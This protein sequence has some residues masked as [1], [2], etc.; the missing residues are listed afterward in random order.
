MP[1][2]KINISVSALS[3]HEYE[4]AFIIPTNSNEIESAFVGGVYMANGQLISAS[5]IKT[6]SSWTDKSPEIV[7]ESEITKHYKGKSIYLGLITLM[8]GHIFTDSSARFWY[9]I[10]ENRNFEKLVF[11]D[12][13][14]DILKVEDKRNE[15]LDILLDILDIPTEKI[16]IV[17]EVSSFENLI[18]PE[19]TIQG[20]T[21]AHLEHINVFKI[22]ASHCKDKHSDILNDWKKNIYIANTDI[23]R[24][25][26]Q[27]KNE[28][29]I[30]NFFESNDYSII[31]PTKLTLSKQIAIIANAD[32]IATLTGTNLYN[33]VFAKEQTTL[34]SIAN[35]K[36]KGRN[37]GSIVIFNHLTQSQFFHIQYVGTTYTS[38]SC[39]ID[40]ENLKGQIS[41]VKESKRFV[42]LSNF[43]KTDYYQALKKLNDLQDENSQYFEIGTNTGNSIK[44]AKA[45][46]VGV[47]PRFVIE[48]DVSDNKKELRFYQVPSDDFFSDYLEKAYRGKKIDLA[49]I[50]GLHHADQ[51]F[52]DIINTESICKSESIITVHDIIPIDDI[53]AKRKRGP[54]QGAW[55]GDVWKA[56]YVLMKERADLKFIFLDCPPSGLLL[57]FNPNNKWK[58]NNKGLY[59]ELTEKADRLPDETLEEYLKMIELV[60]TE[61]FINNF[62]L[63][64][65]FEGIT[66]KR[67]L[68]LENN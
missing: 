62:K 14:L 8:Y 22:I 39:K 59:A 37:Y 11:V 30:I 61:Y 19:K 4:N 40:I 25:S 2:K 31:D 67:P 46:C 32:I 44:L 43:S 60:D 54:N 64:L 27:C 36:F 15:L 52:M 12:P 21:E 5:K 38:D 35:V 68:E 58:E 6:I 3:S 45:Y 66:E 23:N 55:T 50:D 29:E 10:K 33:I 28:D 18:I 47:D 9:L 13:F 34:I 16:L 53:S 56:I 42:K 63:D 65:G 20:E 24:S 1:K 41:L 17:R 48:Q 57:I 51:V 26:L 49:F 7:K